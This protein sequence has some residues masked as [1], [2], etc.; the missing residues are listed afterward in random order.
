MT[1]VAAGLGE[2]GTQRG[3]PLG[4]GL[5]SAWKVAL[6]EADICLRSP[7]ICGPHP[8]LLL[9]PELQRCRPS[10]CSG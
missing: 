2:H 4:K 1:A 9:P 6:S 10:A 5:V 7:E 3:Q 8:I